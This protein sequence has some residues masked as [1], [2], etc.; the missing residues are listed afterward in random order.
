MC[1]GGGCVK[2]VDVWRWWMC[3]GGGCGRW[4]RWWMC[5]SAVHV[6]GVKAY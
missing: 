1:G 5:G 4:V 6:C 2:V 3:E